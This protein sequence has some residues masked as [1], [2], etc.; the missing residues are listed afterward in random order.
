M[1]PRKQGVEYYPDQNGDSFYIRVND[2]G[3]KFPA[4][5]DAVDGSAKQ[6][7]ARGGG[8]ESG[9]HAGRYRLFRNFCVFY[10]R[11]NGLP[12]IRVT[13]LRTGKSNRLCFRSRRMRRIRM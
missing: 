13:D 6:E 4:G 10:Q 1:E 12:Q 9:H 7:L 11:E 8:A 2:T 5:A 3:T